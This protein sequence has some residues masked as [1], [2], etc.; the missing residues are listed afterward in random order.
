MN[1]KNLFSSHRYIIYLMIILPTLSAIPLLYE[2]IESVGIQKGMIIQEDRSSLSRISDGISLRNTL[3]FIAGEL[4]GD[5]RDET[6]NKFNHFVK[7][8]PQTPSVHAIT[9][10][11]A[12][13][14]C[15]GNDKELKDI[16]IYWHDI[17]FR[18][19]MELINNINS[20]FSLR[21]DLVYI[22][23]MFVLI[24]IIFVAYKVGITR[25][26]ARVRIPANDHK[27]P[28]K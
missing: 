25:G 24:S 6:I 19:R 12:D 8:L 4:N 15:S 21:K 14:F 2:R 27:E 26:S 10:S 22:I 5:K 11:M 28:A 3:E 9:S 17:T 20:M 1:V 16:V 7:E 18:E 13:Y 23:P